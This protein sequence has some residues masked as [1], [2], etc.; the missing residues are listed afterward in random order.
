MR[1]QLLGASLLAAL[2]VSACSSGG[3]TIFGRLPEPGAGPQPSTAPVIRMQAALSPQGSYS[4]RGTATL[5]P[6][7]RD[8]NMPHT[9]AVVNLSGAPG[10]ALMPW[11]VHTGVCGSNGP[12]VG[13]AA[14]YT[15]LLVT[16]EG[17]SE[18]TIVLPF[19]MPA[20]TPLH[21]NVHRSPS[22]MGEI[23]ACGPVSTTVSP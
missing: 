11:H 5:T 15:N 23:V 12:I 7:P 4:A 20:D 9:R 8:D 1:F 21:V 2:T 10:N 18:L 6:V 14:S 22:Q 17:N 19:G 16:P 13:V 3:G